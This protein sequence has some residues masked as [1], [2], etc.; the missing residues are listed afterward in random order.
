MQIN[1]ATVI[2]EGD[3]SVGIFP[4]SY[5]LDIYFIFTPNQPESRADLE[6]LRE[7]I[8][9]LYEFIDEGPKVLFDFELEELNR[10]E[11]SFDE[12][13]ELAELEEKR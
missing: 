8:K 13:V 3:R 11:T 7:K 10:A 5:D 9:E 1:K 4:S 12:V 2:F 6:V